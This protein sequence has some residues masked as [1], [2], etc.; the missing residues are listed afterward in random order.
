MITRLGDID[1]GLLDEQY[2]LRAGFNLDGE[3]P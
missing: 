3:R 2:P 1:I